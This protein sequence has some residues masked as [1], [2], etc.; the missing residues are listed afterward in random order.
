MSVVVRIDALGVP[1]GDQGGAMSCPD[2]EGQG[3]R[4]VRVRVEWLAGSTLTDE[5]RPCRCGEE[6]V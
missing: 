2:C 3:G 4:F 5:W 1:R 6:P